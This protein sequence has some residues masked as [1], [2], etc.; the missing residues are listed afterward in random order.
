MRLFEGRGGVDG[1]AVLGLRGGGEAG[2][3]GRRLDPQRLRLLHVEQRAD[4]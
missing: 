3:A 1:V 4:I 2:E